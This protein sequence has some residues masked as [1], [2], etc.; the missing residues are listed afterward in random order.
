MTQ[1]KYPNSPRGI[2]LESLC[3]DP[4]FGALKF[5]TALPRLD[6]MKTE[7]VELEELDY[8]AHLTQEEIKKIDSTKNT[9]TN[10]VQQIQNFDLSQG[11]PQ[12]TRDNIQNQIV[13]FYDSTFAIYTRNS[14][15][16]LRQQLRLDKKTEKELRQAIANAKKIE[17]ELQ[18]RLTKIKEEEKSVEKGSG[19]IASK[20]LSKE[21]EDQFNIHEGSSK[22]WFKATIGFYIALFIAATGSFITY[23]SIVKTTNDKNLYIEWA[24]FNFLL[25]AIIFYGLRLSNRNFNIHKNLAAVNRHRRNVAETLINFLSS[26]K[27][28]EIIK[29]TLIKDASV[30]LFEHKTTG[31][32]TKDQTQV[33]TPVQEMITKIITDKS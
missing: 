25:I 27:N 2:D 6:K 22:G 3:L 12:Q 18:E 13:N 7:L 30:A 1:E 32:L 15:I 33:G 14:L 21:F 9:F 24:I 17:A 4:R 19:I 29:S 28:D 5:E 26:E 10:F 11:N 16:Y 23:L 31:Y 20:F 8:K